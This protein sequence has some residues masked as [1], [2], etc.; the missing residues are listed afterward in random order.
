MFV[1]NAFASNVGLVSIK[2]LEVLGA[3]LCCYSS[4][5]GHSPGA[6]IPAA[7]F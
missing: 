6:D 2:V 4:H 1:K 7:T 3:W 5:L